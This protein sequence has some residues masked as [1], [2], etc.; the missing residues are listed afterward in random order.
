MTFSISK[1]CYYKL[2]KYWFKE[3]GDQVYEKALFEVNSNFHK[4]TFTYVNCSQF[5]FCKKFG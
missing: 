4:C 2:G 1:I 5:E 3:Q